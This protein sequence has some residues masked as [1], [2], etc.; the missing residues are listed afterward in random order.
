MAVICRLAWDELEV[1]LLHGLDATG[2]P[3][4]Y[5]VFDLFDPTTPCATIYDTMIREQLLA[6]AQD[7]YEF[8]HRIGKPARFDLA[9]LVLNYFGV[10]ISGDKKATP[11]ADGG[12]KD[13]WRLRYHELDGVP[14]TE[15]PPEARDYAT[16][17]ATWAL[18]VAVAQ[19]VAQQHD[20][21]GVL[22]DEQGHVT[23]EYQQTAAAFALHL[24]AIWGVRTDGAMVETFTEETE[25]AV[26]EAEESGRK[27]GFLRANGSRDMKKLYDCVS[28]A[29]DGK[30][31]RNAPTGR[32]PEGSVK[33]DADTLKNSGD[34]LL[35]AYAEGSIHRTTLQRY[36]PQLL[37]GVDV[38]MTSR[39]R[40]LKRSGRCA[41]SN[42]N[43][44]NPPRRGPYRECHKARPGYLY[45]SADWSGA[46]L[47]GLAQ[48]CVWWFG[49]SY[50]ADAFKAGRD[51]HMELGAQM[52]NVSYEEAL[53]HPDRADARQSAKCF[54]VSTEV[55]TRRGWVAVEELQRHDFVAVPHPPAKW[56]KAA[57]RMTWEHPLRLTT[58]WSDDVVRVHNE[59]LD[60][61]CTRDHAF[62]AYS[63]GGNRGRYE[64]AGLT[65][66]RYW[67][68]AAL[69]E[70]TDLA[71][72]G[73]D[74]LFEALL[75][76]AVAVQA[77]GSYQGSD[78][79]RFGFSRPRKISRLRG[80]FRA[81]G[82][83]HE[84][85][86]R[87]T[88]QG[89]QEFRWKGSGALL[90]RRL[91][92]ENKTLPWAWLHLEAQYRRVVLEE[93]RFWDGQ[94]HNGTGYHY[95]S[96][97]KKNID[98]LQALAAITGK[99]AAVLAVQADEDPKHKDLHTLGMRKHAYTRGENLACDAVE[100]QQVYCLTTTSG[101][102]IVRGPSRAPIVAHQCGNFGYP[103]GLG[104]ET[105]VRWCAAQGL[106]LSRDGTYE[107]AV[108]HAEEIK[109]A[110]FRTWP[111]VR[112]YLDEIGRMA[113][114]GSFTA[115]QCCSNR[116]RGGCNYTAG[117]NTYFQGIVADFAKAS[118]WRVTRECYTG[119]A[120]D[121]VTCPGRGPDV[122]PP[123]VWE[124]GDGPQ[125]S[126]LHGS[127]PWLL[128]HDEI[129]IEVP[130]VVPGAAS[131]AVKRMAEIM[132]LTAEQYTP[133]VPHEAEPA[134]MR[135]WYKSAKPVWK[136]GVVGGE[137]LVWE[138]EPKTE[139]E[140][141][142]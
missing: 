12:E 137:L 114:T 105:F 50:L 130:D 39:P 46:E 59:A 92:D 134:L 57:P 58:R 49:Q 68:S 139:K 25:R 110:W 107:D 76:L 77:D 136:D 32:F 65:K 69:E 31:P 120:Y 5:N 131:A 73:T 88:T 64:A 56:S 100:P 45:G 6:I 94:A 9:T 61:V 1:D 3:L 37:Q 140:T 26:A 103:G 51:P 108:R 84:V 91:L 142:T 19:S 20:G 22:V 48:V 141:T 44:H 102:V 118:H 97:V 117:A 132:V 75:R 10:D 53:E 128:L 2:A 71:A 121:A 80:L 96:T 63:S 112:Q 82:R 38:A 79:V 81:A 119:V 74:P 34:P 23:D 138:P 17:D 27:A 36:I 16:D 106:D 95:S 78:C 15:W 113:Q 21:G 86:E 115:V 111:E 90:V 104:T 24:D 123:A 109:T 116:A 133:D 85:R 125:D 33:T 8:D 66:A 72:Y 60:L 122:P 98:V 70:D 87:I 127:R 14:L 41:W 30:P 101:C 43:Q 54:G 52:L 40:A 93:A 62:P 28:E 18:R 11:A 129:L 67:Y 47:R 35:V 126:A 89:A 13:P 29:Y 7:R 4:G 99:K 135:R 124:G 83:S 55:L 42:P